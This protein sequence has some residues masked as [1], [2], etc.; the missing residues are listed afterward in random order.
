[1][2]T[3]INID[4]LVGPTHH[5]GGLGVG[6]LASMAHERQASHPKLAALEGVAKAALVARLGVPQFVWLPPL[7]PRFDL[8]SPYGFQGSL[9]EQLS[10][11]QRLAPR[12]L[13]AI[14]SSAFMWAANAATVSPAVDTRDQRLH[15]TPANLIS[16]WHRATEANE[17]ALDM[18]ELFQHALPHVTVHP[19]LPSI[20][21]LRDE[22]AAN[23]M[24]LCD[25]SGMR[26]LN[27]FVYGEEDAASEPTCRFLPRQTRAA[28]EA[29]ARAHQLDPN[30]TF[31]L[32]Q[33][34]AAISAGVFHNDVIATSHQGLLIHHALAFWE[35]ENCLRQ[36]E[37]AFQTHTGQ[38]LLRLEISHHELPLPLA[39]Q[40]YFF[41]SQLLTPAGSDRMTLVCPAQCQAIEAARQLI[42]RLITDPRVPIDSV[43]YVSLQ[44]SMANGGGPACLRLRVPVDVQVLHGMNATLRMDDNLAECLN[45]AI[46]RWYPDSVTS[47]DLIDSEF[48]AAARRAVSE[49]HQAVRSS[50]G[51]RHHG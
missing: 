50:S 5:F 18:E 25:P 3:E 6:N 43:H 30:T 47:D 33:H 1:M 26:G 48:V 21:P 40:S 13:S 29:I 10:A 28:C 16:S 35:G 37:A 36:I 12:A 34:P 4:A 23:H 14:F 17:R 38:P 2:L 39:V 46:D 9:S 42:E 7:R 45:A 31:F 49:V 41:N 19:P 51:R 15:M 44:E 27:L 22:G 32:R 24:R 20:I 11:A 8:L